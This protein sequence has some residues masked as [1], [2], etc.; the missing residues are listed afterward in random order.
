MNICVICEDC[1]K[2]H[3]GDC[4]VHGPLAT[5][6]PSSG[7]NTA[8]LQYTSVPVPRELTVKESK[9][10][11]AGLGVFATELIPNGVKFG[12]YKGQKVYYED[13][14]EDD[15]TS[16]MWEIKKP[17]ES[18]YID[19]QVESES[20]WMRYINCAR[21]EEEQNLVAFQY[22]GEIYYRTFKDI[23]PG[24][25]LFVWYG[26]QYAKDLGIE[27]TVNNYG[28]FIC[29][30]C[31]NRFKSKSNFKTHLQ[32]N[33]DCFKANPQ[34][35]TC[36]RCQESFYALHKLQDHIRKHEEV[37][38]ET[39]IRFV[40]IEENVTNNEERY[41]D[42]AKRRRKADCQRRFHCEY[43]N[44]SFT[45]RG[46]LN[47]HIRIHTGE[48]Y[49]CQYCDKSFT[50]RDNLDRHIRTHTGEKPYHCEYCD[51]SFT[52]SG[53]LNRHI[54]IHTGE[55]PYHCEYC[56]ASFTESGTLN[57]HIRT[58]TGEKP[59]HCKYCDASFTTS[60][61]LNTHI[62]IHTGEKPYH[63]KYCDKSFTQSSILTRHIRAVHN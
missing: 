21:N 16:Y 54:R 58:H 38:T 42:G 22:H 51:A 33:K 26:D 1:Q 17:N 40:K 34:I 35:F 59:Y 15:D 55:K 12:P 63:C 13:I 49:H 7:Y 45:Q 30:R 46:S 9:I 57:T 56:D 6:D 32:S 44:K 27:T 3:H 24:T 53:D 60:G 41:R 18:Y 10:P 61:H 36:G 52:T 28:L 11:K 39:K 48:T 8:S 2:I 37:K 31:S 20:N 23:C 29:K 4:P 62:R 50:I 5:L 14:D 43:C 25:E 19:G 47:T